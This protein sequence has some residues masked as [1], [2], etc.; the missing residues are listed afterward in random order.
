MGTTATIPML[1]EAYPGMIV[2]TAP[3]GEVL[4]ESDAWAALTG[5]YRIKHDYCRAGWTEE[6][7]EDD[8][9]TG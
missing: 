3:A 6:L 4:S 8:L 7:R 9:E 2:K 1:A 5:H